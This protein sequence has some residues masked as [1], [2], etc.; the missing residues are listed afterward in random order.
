VLSTD[1][2]ETLKRKKSSAQPKPEEQ[3]ENPIDE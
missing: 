1:L 2:S 3:G